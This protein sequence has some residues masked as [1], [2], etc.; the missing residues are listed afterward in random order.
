M[1]NGDHGHNANVRAAVELL[2]EHGRWLQDDNFVAACIGPAGDDCLRVD[3]ARAW[4]YARTY[5]A[6]ED[7]RAMLIFIADLGSGRCN[8]GSPDAR[9]RMGIAAATM[10]ALVEHW[11]SA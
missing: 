2:I 1:G 8:L 11:Q 6:S 4:N 3:F 9:D 10:H 7:Q 5:R